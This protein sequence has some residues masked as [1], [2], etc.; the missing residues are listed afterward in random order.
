M[1]RPAP[2]TTQPTL[3]SSLMKVR[4]ARRAATSLGASA[5]SSRSA[6]RSGRRSSSL[7]S[8]A[9]LAS[10]ASTSPPAVVTSGLISA[11]EAPLALKTV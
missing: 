8:I 5:D 11:S 2:L 3:P 10:S 1:A 7:S 6:A 9:I 4:P